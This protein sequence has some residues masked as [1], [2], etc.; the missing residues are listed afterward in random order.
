MVESD[1]FFNF[2]LDQKVFHLG[3]LV[4]RDPREDF[5]R[6]NLGWR[7]LDEGLRRAQGRLVWFNETIST[8]NCDFK[9]LAV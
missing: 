6:E 7:N 5:V 4:I 2:K 9:L 1:R 8:W 3:E